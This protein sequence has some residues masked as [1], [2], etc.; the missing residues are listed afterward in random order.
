MALHQLSANN[1]QAT[2]S[3]LS[4]TPGIKGAPSG[5]SELALESI[6]TL[7]FGVDDAFERDLRQRVNLY[8]KQGNGKSKAG[9]WRMY[10]KTAIILTS[11]ATFY[12]LLVFVAGNIWQG[13]PL[14]VLLGLT[15]AAIGFN[16]SHD[17]GHRAYSESP[18]VNKAMAMT[19]DLVGGSSYIWF[20]KHSVIHHNYVNIT[21]YDTDIDHGNIGR[22]SPYQEWHPY[23]RWQHIYL[24]FL[25]GLLAV[26]WE[27]VH[28]FKNVIAG[29]I[30]KHK[31][32]RPKGWDLVIFIGGKAFFY[33]WALVIPL[34]Y[35]SPLIVLFFYFIGSLILGLTISVVFQLPH[36]VGEVDFSLPRQDNGEIENPWAVHQA[37]ATADYGWHSP[38]LSWF[39]GGLNFHLEHHLL[40]TICHV[41]YKGLSKIVVETCH[42]HGVKYRKHKSFWSGVA[43]H[44]RWLKKMGQPN[45]QA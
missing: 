44:Y 21:D 24:W 42:D 26:K 38:F 15:T 37:N 17:G 20:W 1:T 7:D 9:D 13:L 23:Y 22:M 25:Y 35:H 16:I 18:W 39:V 10:L 4:R 40:P 45:L 33:T 11:F 27:F 36:C 6:F 19:L 34:L 41:H 29:R 2:E 5:R 43:A 3:E 32:P 31:I 8:F 28:D 14:V 30:G 12:F